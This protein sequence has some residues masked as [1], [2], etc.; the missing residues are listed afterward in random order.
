MFDLTG[1]ITIF[2][3]CIKE[4]NK[5]NKTIQVKVRSEKV[6]LYPGRASTKISVSWTNPLIEYL[7][8]AEGEKVVR[9]QKTLSTF[10][11]TVGFN[12]RSRSKSQVYHFSMDAAG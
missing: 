1:L 8:T 10:Q 11:Q 3:Y 12:G 2:F 6:F 7:L 4:R 5:E 9:Q